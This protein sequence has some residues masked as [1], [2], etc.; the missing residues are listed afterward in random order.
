MLIGQVIKI[1][2][3]NIFMN[4][5]R[6]YSKGEIRN[7]RRERDGGR[8]GVTSPGLSFFSKPKKCNPHCNSNKQIWSTTVPMLE[9]SQKKLLG[10]VIFSG[11]ESPSSGCDERAQQLKLGSIFISS[12]IN[13]TTSTSKE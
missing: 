9:G 5:S 8:G 11:N 12:K 3:M 4:G 13:K 1:I 10:E 2:I 7:M 6:E